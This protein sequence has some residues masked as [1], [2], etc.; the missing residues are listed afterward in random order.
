MVHRS[1]QRDT[2]CSRPTA[3]NQVALF[4]TPCNGDYLGVR[5]I[6]DVVVGAAI[7]EIEK[8]RSVSDDIA[9]GVAD[10]DV[11][12]YKKYDDNI[13]LYG[14]IVVGTAM[15]L[16]LFMVAIFWPLGE[17][18]KVP[19]GVAKSAAGSA[20]F[21]TVLLAILSQDCSQQSSHSVTDAQTQ[22]QSSNEQSANRRLI[23]TST[24]TQPRT[25]SMNRSRLTSMLP[26][27]TSQRQTS[28]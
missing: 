6:S 4:D 17:Q 9:D 8:V 21:A 12:S 5:A 2:I 13:N 26:L 14:P 24:A 23:F 19:S 22:T 20:I 3:S 10:I 18:K 7:S 25:A 28:N 27:P 15:L 1:R 16:P 11:S